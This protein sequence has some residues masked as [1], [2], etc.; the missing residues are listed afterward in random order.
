M[1][2]V[3]H[4]C[5][6]LTAVLRL[7]YRQIWIYRQVPRDGVEGGETT[8]CFIYTAGPVSSICQSI[9][10]IASYT[11]SANKQKEGKMAEALG[12]IGL[13]GPAIS[14]CISVCEFWMRAEGTGKEFSIF[15]IR[16]DLQS[17]RLKTWKLEWGMEKSDE[18]MMSHPLFKAYAPLAVRYLYLIH[19]LLLD[20]QNVDKH[21]GFHN[22]ESSNK[23]I[24]HV[25]DFEASEEW[26]QTMQDTFASVNERAGV[27]GR[28]RW[29]M[30]TPRAARKSL[31]VL[32][33]LV[34]DLTSFFRAPES[35]D[36]APTVLGTILPSN[37]R[38]LVKAMGTYNESNKQKDNSQSI[39]EYGDEDVNKAERQLLSALAWVK[40]AVSA[41]ADR[42]AVSKSGAILPVTQ[43]KSIKSDTRNSRATGQLQGRDVFVEWKLVP[44]RTKS[45][46]APIF[47]KRV[48][49]IADLLRSDRKPSQFRT[50]DCVG[51]VREIKPDYTRFGLVFKMESSKWFT[52]RD[53][54]AVSGRSIPLGDRF[55]AATALAKAILYLHLASW[56]H[57]AIRSD[58]V[59]YFA[60]STESV[61]FKW[62]FLIGFDMSRPSSEN[63]MTE[64]PQG[65]LRFNLYRHPR[66]QGLPIDVEGSVDGEP[67][68]T[69]HTTGNRDRF[70]ALH[71]LYSFG[72][73]LIEL[74]EGRH[75][76]DMCR[77]EKS[78]WFKGEFDAQQMKTWLVEEKVPALDAKM[79]VL[80]RDATLLCLN[81]DFD[82]TERSLQTAFYL[83]VVR[84]LEQCNA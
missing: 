14:G 34:D 54:F 69:A 15:K 64:V 29:A 55:L 40:E 10:F 2:L 73:I 1:K 80:Y 7:I 20:L 51:L 62:P 74:A 13:V 32:K 38:E 35:L 30:D 53:L 41:M 24:K 60:P 58:N 16:L 33:D 12:I 48:K 49:D 17:A 81:S 77:A 82:V 65:E 31:V 6:T 42:V 63:E 59:V 19:F 11:S 79:G 68:A 39:D 45:A 25:V 8:P 28:I 26:V 18:A 27:I 61:D 76:E 66:V 3:P 5:H 36:L 71:D 75:I 83:D 50:L 43:L 4:A 23:R 37:D 57:K 52:M 78:D 22:R 84:R 67:Q 56:L 72:I 46:H 47:E 21:L 9:W 70:S 44:S